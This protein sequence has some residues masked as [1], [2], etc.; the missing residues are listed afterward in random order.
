MGRHTL[1]V[2]LTLAVVWIV[3]VEDISW[4]TV[5]MGLLVAAI[6]LHLVGKYLPYEEIKRVNFFRLIAFPFFLVGQ[7]YGS[8]FTVIKHIFKGHKLEI[9]KVSTKIK[10]ETLR[11]VLA[12]TITLTPGSILLDLT[13][14]NAVILWMRSKDTIADAEMAGELIKGKLEREL[15]KADKDVET[16]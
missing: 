5:G 10:N 8:G 13:G 1:F 6:C 11:V 9:V 14:D 2:H 16:E 4:R 3:L 15:I 7:I 12:D